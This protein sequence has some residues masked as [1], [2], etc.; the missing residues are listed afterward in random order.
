MQHAKRNRLYAHGDLTV[1]FVIEVCVCLFTDNSETQ[2][3]IKYTQVSRFKEKLILVLVLEIMMVS[4][5]MQEED[6]R[7]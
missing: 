2:K 4:I 7:L 1:V 6:Y 5:N 3:K